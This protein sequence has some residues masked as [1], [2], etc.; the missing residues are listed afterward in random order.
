VFVNDVNKLVKKRQSNK[1]RLR[2]TF[3]IK[4]KVKIKIS[5]VVSLLYFVVCCFI[6]ACY[7]S[8]RN[9]GYENTMKTRSSAIAE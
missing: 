3:K 7:D 5:F 6:F 4:V 8:R 2:L 9:K 1:L